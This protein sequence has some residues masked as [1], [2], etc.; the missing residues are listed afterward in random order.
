MPRGFRPHLPRVQRLQLRGWGCSPLRTHG[1]VGGSH[2]ALGYL[3]RWQKCHWSAM[4]PGAQVPQGWQCGLAAPWHPVGGRDGA[5]GRWGWA[6][7][8][9]PQEAPCHLLRPPLG[10][11]HRWVP[12]PAGPRRASARRQLHPAPWAGW[13][14]ALRPGSPPMCCQGPCPALL[15]VPPLQR[16]RQKGSETPVPGSQPD[17]RTTGTGITRQRC[18]S[19]PRRAE[20]GGATPAQRCT[21]R[22]KW[23]QAHVT[24]SPLNRHGRPSSGS[25]TAK[26]S[27]GTGFPVVGATF[28]PSPLRLASSPS[29]R[30]Q[31]SPA[32]C[33]AKPRSGTDPACWTPA[34]GGTDGCPRAS[35][36]CTALHQDTGAP[37][38]GAPSAGGTGMAGATRAPTG[39]SDLSLQSRRLHP[40]GSS[41]HPSPGTAAAAARPTRAG[42]LAPGCCALPNC[43]CHPILLRGGRTPQFCTTAKWD[44][45][46]GDGRGCGERGGRGQVTRGH[47]GI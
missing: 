3:S 37:A 26:P 8:E 4:S 38:M 45:C 30:Q 23:P 42:R 6:A 24:L 41:L 33:A 18:R 44:A 16:A 43:P 11:G 39:A 12:L 35:D 28:S 7:G 25:A 32:L 47:G 13:G 14:L 36:L 27:P 9:T 21:G 34:E 19:C 17:H 40:C 10:T 2:Q 22:Q 31:P 29:S 15:P 5:W 1:C 46:L 20:L